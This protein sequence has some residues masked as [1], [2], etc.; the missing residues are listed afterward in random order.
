MLRLLCLLSLGG[1]VQSPCAG[2]ET[3]GRE[4][5]LEGADTTT[6][7]LHDGDCSV[8]AKPLP[9]LTI[10]RSRVPFEYG[11]C[12]RRNGVPLYVPRGWTVE[13]VTRLP[14]RR[15]YGLSA[16]RRDLGWPAR[17]CP[18]AL[19][20]TSAYGGKLR[21]YFLSPPDVSSRF[22]FRTDPFGFANHTGL[23]AA[24]VLLLLLGL[25]NEYSL[26]LLRAKRWKALQRWNY[27]GFALIMVHGGTYQVLEKRPRPFIGALTALVLTVVML[28]LAGFSMRRATTKVLP[29]GGQRRRRKE[30][31]SNY[32]KVVPM[33]QEVT[34]SAPPE[35]YSPEYYQ[36]IAALEHRH[37]WHRGMREIAM[38]LI[39]SCETPA[40][41]SCILD[42]GCGTGA[43]LLWAREMLGAQVVIG[44][45]V[46]RPALTFCHVRGDHPLLQGSVL[47]LPFRPASFDLIIRQDVLQHL[48]TDGA[49]ARVIVTFY[50]VLRPGG[51]MLVRANSRL[52]MG[53]EAALRDTDFQRYTLLEV[54]SLLQTAG[55]IVKRATYANAL[56]A[57]PAL[58]KQWW[59]E[60]RRY[61]VT[62]PRRL[63]EGFRMRD[64]A[65]EHAW[66]N[67]CLLWILRAEARY[68]SA[69]GRHLE[70]GHS[71]FCLGIR[72]GGETL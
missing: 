25:S 35:I 12:L 27:A 67:Q 11:L 66:L 62:Q 30:D 20:G 18:C 16:R 7:H 38:A 47:Q 14:A 32:A 39:K 61:R 21:L 3:E 37:W 9:T 42:A 15:E 56:P 4:Y 69:P 60:S 17:P 63:Y 40:P 54:A 44:M 26:R 13:S 36:C 24:L 55:F 2:D 46:A 1:S 41:L 59:R 33:D 50:E 57:V 71:T 68:L 58:V 10:R 72:P 64:T 23:A 45:D 34:N 19:R 52:G 43:G 29:M 31:V 5:T 53:Q 6:H 8:C 22:F 65:A 48:P 49:D 51:L 70:F 28:Q